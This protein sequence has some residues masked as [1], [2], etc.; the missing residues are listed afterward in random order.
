VQ[1]YTDPFSSYTMR[2]LRSALCFIE[3]KKVPKRAFIQTINVHNIYSFDETAPPVIVLLRFYLSKEN[4]HYII[5]PSH[6]CIS[7]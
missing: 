7:S 1:Y 5:F 3:T 6:F 2:T 4:L